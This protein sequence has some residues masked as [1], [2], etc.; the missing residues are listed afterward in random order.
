MYDVISRKKKLEFGEKHPGSKE[1]RDRW[2]RILKHSNYISFSKLR[3]TFPHIDQVNQ[4]SDPAKEFLIDTLS[5]LIK[6]YEE[7]YSEEPESDPLG[8][9]KFLFRNHYISD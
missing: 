9:L 5:T 2:H 1:A 6:D 4:E 8:A 3:E 7:R